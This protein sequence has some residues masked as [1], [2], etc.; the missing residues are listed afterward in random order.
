VVLIKE[1]N[2]H[3]GSRVG[4][5]GSALSALD[6][7]VGSSDSAKAELKRFIRNF[8]E[9]EKA[10]FLY[11]EVLCEAKKRLCFFA[12][13]YLFICLFVYLDNMINLSVPLLDLLLVIA[14]TNQS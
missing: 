14:V 11:L 7:G 1:P 9:E 3:V 6:M 13:F 4:W 10:T 12:R 8:V 5:S 2:D